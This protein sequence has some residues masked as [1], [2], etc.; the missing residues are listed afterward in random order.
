MINIQ[1]IQIVIDNNNLYFK[2][3]DIFIIMIGQG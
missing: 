2:N 1:E 3:N